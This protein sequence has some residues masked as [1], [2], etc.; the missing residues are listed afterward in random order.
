[1]K[2]PM[3]LI[4]TSLLVACGVVGS[5]VPPEYVG[6]APTIEKQKKQHAL[7]AERD[8]VDTG[9]PDLSLEGHDIGLPPSQP[10][11]TR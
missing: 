9:V 4:S 11:G 2:A 6:V 8:T 3:I 5:P 10:M 1:M 7:Q